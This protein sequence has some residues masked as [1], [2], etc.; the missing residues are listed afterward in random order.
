MPPLRASARPAPQKPAPQ[1]CAKP[2]SKPCA[3]VSKVV[4]GPQITTS[5]AYFS[6]LQQEHKSKSTARPVKVVLSAQSNSGNGKDYLDLCRSDGRKLRVN[7]GFMACFYDLNTCDVMAIMRISERSF[8]RIKTF[9]KLAKWPKQLLSR[10]H[11]LLTLSNVRQSRL[12]WMKWSYE[13]RDEFT[14]E[15]LHR[16]HQCAGCS[17]VDLPSP[18][19]VSAPRPVVQRVCVLTAPGAVA[20]CV[21]QESDSAPIV[22]PHFQSDLSPTMATQSNPQPEPETNPQLEPESNPQPELEPEQ[23]Q[24]VPV[25]VPC[26]EQPPLDLEGVDF[27][28]E[29]VDWSQLFM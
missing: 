18:C 12:N 15:L 27:D 25:P 20:Q 6:Y 24:N 3:S 14:Y 22:Q 10:G 29:G 21:F 1:V 28:F 7:P 9:C 8:N 17:V 19:I 4:I 26:E 23:L 16:A 13:Q 5:Q 2:I 11:G